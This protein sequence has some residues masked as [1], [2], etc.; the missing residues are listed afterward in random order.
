MSTEAEKDKSRRW[1]KVHLPQIAARSRKYREEHPEKV[2]Q[3]AANRKAAGKFQLY[4]KRRRKSAIERGICASCYNAPSAAGITVCQE[5]SAKRKAERLHPANK[6]K[7]K[8]YAEIRKQ[9]LI[10]AGTCIDCAVFPATNGYIRCDEC[11]LK[12]AQYAKKW[13][14]KCILS[15]L[16]TDCGV[17][18][19][20]SNQTSSE[21]VKRCRR[22]LIRNLARVHLGSTS[23]AH[24]LENMLQKQSYRC[25]YSGLPLEVG[26]NASIDHIIAKSVRP[27]LRYEP[28]NLQWVDVDVNRMK[29]DKTHEE[30][31]ALIERIYRHTRN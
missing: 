18:P 8:E 6:Q 3:W 4:S 13:R 28:S 23:K 20:L 12:V 21:T 27:D 30:F 7:R 11:R 17:E 22:C 29:S 2:A 16:C 31:I 1:A 25:P 19:F 9:S 5:C 24:V 10:A 14:G 26:G 15:G